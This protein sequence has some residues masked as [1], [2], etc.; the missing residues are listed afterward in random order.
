MSIVFKSI[1]CVK[2][3][4]TQDNICDWR[5]SDSVI[6]IN[7]ELA[8]ALRGLEEFSHLIV[9]FHLDKV[10]ERLKGSL[11]PLK[12][13][14]RG[15]EDISKVGLF[16]TRSPMRPNPIACTVVQLLGI[17]GNHIFVRGLDAID[18]SPVIDIKPVVNER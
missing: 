9:L 16:A 15:R 17:E 8:E 12:V 6:V 2:S 14:P 3:N 11:P 1:G 10:Y 18:G 4:L 5:K 7:S 13:H